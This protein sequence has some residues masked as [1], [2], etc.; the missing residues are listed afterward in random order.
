VVAVVIG[1]PTRVIGGASWRTPQRLGTAPAECGIS[2]RAKNENLL[3][4][5]AL[6]PASA[7]A[8]FTALAM[9]AR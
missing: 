2:I 5:P 3:S 8:T 7:L 6:R 4:E 9:P 1:R